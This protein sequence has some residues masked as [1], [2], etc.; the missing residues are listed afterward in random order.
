[1]KNNKKICFVIMP[2]GKFGTE[3]F[4]RNLKIHNIMFKPVAEICGYDVI[5]ADFFLKSESNL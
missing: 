2:F 5:R 3:E 4:Q 1:M